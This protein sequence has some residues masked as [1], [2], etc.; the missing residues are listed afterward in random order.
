MTI[1]TK[2]KALSPN[3]FL[4]DQSFLL[5]G[6]FENMKCFFIIFWEGAGQVRAPVFL[7]VNL[8]RTTRDDAA[9][10]LAEEG[11]VTTPV[12]WVHTALEVTENARKV[13]TST[14][15]KPQRNTMAT[16]QR[17]TMATPQ[18]DTMATPQKDTMA[19]PQRP[20]N[21]SMNYDFPPDQFM[22]SVYICHKAF[23]VNSTVKDCCKA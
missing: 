20:S 21:S 7:R 12:S 8:A 22:V 13:Q 9:A 19:T 23:G 10:V 6:V 5:K 15:A 17:D 3:K 18:R 11:I 1:K 2:W 16:S 14:M 4:E